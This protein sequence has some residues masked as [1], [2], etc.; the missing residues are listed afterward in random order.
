MN[1][2]SATIEAF[3]NIAKCEFE[4]RGNHIILR[5][6]NGSG[7]TAILE[8][9]TMAFFGKKL[10]PDDPVMHGQ[11]SS[12]IVWNIG[13]NEKLIFTITIRVTADNFTLKVI[14]YGDNG[15]KMEIK[16]P[17]GFLEKIMFKDALDP[18]AFFSKSDKDQ[19]QMLYTIL[20][21]LKEQLDQIDSDIIDVKSVRSRVL[22]E[23]Q[24]AEVDLSRI[25]YTP[26]LPEAEIDPVDLVAEL[27]RANEKN[28][29]LEDMQ[30]DRQAAQD[31]LSGIA[32]KKTS[33]KK[34]I[35]RQAEMIRQMQAQ[36]K[37]SENEFTSLSDTEKS[38]AE[39]IA[40][41]DKA[42]QD[43]KPVDTADIEN[44]I[45]SVKDTNQKIRD[46]LRRKELEKRVEDLSAEFSKGLKDIRDLEEKRIEV[47]KS[48]QMPIEGLTVGEGC[49]MF[50]DP[51]TG[52]IVRLNSLSTGQKWR[53]AVRILAAFLP[54][55]GMRVMIVKNVNDLDETN[56]NAML[57]AADELGIQLVMHQT[58][59][60][61]DNSQ[62]EIVIEDKQ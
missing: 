61:S 42:I 10:L 37:E 43:F 59:F 8:A 44:R 21:N 11:E 53:V 25:E 40:T 16:S 60:K 7:K 36:M 20:P 51:V 27:T 57:A 34:Q 48:A 32:Q 5:G 55:N 45:A 15:Q 28:A 6:M 4:A 19:L 49:L 35:E 46:N 54:E 14:Q 58:V 12:K 62:C 22:S 30:S 18:Q 2:H 17:A 33:I 31:Q 13:N 26:N 3:K 29:E 47:I 50:P 23:K 9:L 24:A 56:Y 52:E 41:I 1:I 39:K 38:I